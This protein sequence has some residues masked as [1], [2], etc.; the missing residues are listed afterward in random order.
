LTTSSPSATAPLPYQD[1]VLLPA[2]H[3]PNGWPGTDADCSAAADD[4]TAAASADSA[5]PAH[6][7][8][9]ISSLLGTHGGWGWGRRRSNDSPC[10]VGVFL[11]FKMQLHV[12]KMWINISWINEI[13]WIVD[14]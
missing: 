10:L 5:A 11:F 3:F 4:S 1:G 13:T 7:R 12:L 2:G 9:L 6:H 8:H 14:K